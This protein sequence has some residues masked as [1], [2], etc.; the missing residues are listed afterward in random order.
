MLCGKADGFV[1]MLAGNRVKQQDGCV[2]PACN[3]FFI[4]RQTDRIRDERGRFRQFVFRKPDSGDTLQTDVG[5]S[6][7]RLG[8]KFGGSH[9]VA[10]VGSL[11]GS[12]VM[13]GGYHG[14][15]EDDAEDDGRYD[16]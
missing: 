3:G 9:G 15:Y 6:A 4:G 7:L 14:S 10:V 5:L 8:F 12:A 1:K 11:D 16:F 2:V 13:A